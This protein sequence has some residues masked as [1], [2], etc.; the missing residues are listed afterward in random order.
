[1]QLED[2]NEVLSEMTEACKTPGMKKRSKGKG[3]GLARGKG[4]GPVGKPGASRGRFNLD[5]VNEGLSG[6]VEALS[7][8]LMESDYVGHH[9]FDG[10]DYYADTAFMNM[11][12]GVMKGMEMHHLGFGE[13]YMKGPQGEIEFDRMRGKDFPGQSGRSHKLYDNKNGKLVK[14]LI[15]AMEKKKKSKLVKEG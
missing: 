15:K 14:E 1:M 8:S 2:L 7:N 4:K 12:K 10:K 13:F 9:Y 6:A 11:T 5:D 3:R